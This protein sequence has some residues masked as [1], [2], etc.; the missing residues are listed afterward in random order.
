[1]GI[2][3]DTRRNLAC[4]SLIGLALMVIVFIAFLVLIPSTAQPALKTFTL[5]INS[6]QVTVNLPEALPEMDTALYAGQECFNLKVCRQEFCLNPLPN[7]DHVDFMFTD[8]GE[9]FALIWIRTLKAEYMVWKYVGGMPVLSTLEEIK[10]IILGD[11]VKE[12]L[13]ESLNG[14]N[15]RRF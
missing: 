4:L 1:M 14:R 6:K 7:H 11:K 8:E 5:T 2:P 10:A 9:V 13:K 3:T 12:I 15:R